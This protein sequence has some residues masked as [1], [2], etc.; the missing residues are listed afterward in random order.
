MYKEGDFI[1]CKKSTGVFSR[2]EKWIITNVS[3]NK[4]ITV[5]NLNDNKCY[6]ISETNLENYFNTLSEHRK[7]IIDSI[8][9]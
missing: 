4:L 3:D 6:I 2:G 8:Y 7:L 9:E 5:Q 1:F